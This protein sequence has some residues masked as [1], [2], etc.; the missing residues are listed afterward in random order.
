MNLFLVI[1]AW[2]VIGAILAIGIVM[3][4]KGILWLLILSSVLFIAA[5]SKWG[6]ATH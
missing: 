2:L 6:C 1:L 4:T 5:F 3:A